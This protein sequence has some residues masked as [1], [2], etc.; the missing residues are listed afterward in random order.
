MWITR[1]LTLQCARGSKK[2]P[3]NLHMLFIFLLFLITLFYFTIK[4]VKNSGEDTSNIA[5]FKR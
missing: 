2:F 5:Y 4:S 1:L 3:R